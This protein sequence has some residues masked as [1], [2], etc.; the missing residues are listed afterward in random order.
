MTDLRQTERDLYVAAEELRG[1]ATEFRQRREDL[2]HEFAGTDPSD[3]PD[4]AERE[5]QRLAEQI[6]EAEGTA[7]TYD[8]YAD[9]WSVDGAG[10]VFVVEELNGDEYA[11]TIDAVSAEAGRQAR[12][13]GSLPQGYGRVKALEYGIV[14]KPPGAPADPGQWP[15]PIVGELFDALQNL[16]APSGVELG[17]ESLASAVSGRTGETP[18]TPPAASTPNDD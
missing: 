10:C 5:Y 18:D 12:E 4:D 1:D 8:H 13:D 7:N 6:K 14:D 17:N 11:A 15:A 16:T 2:E 9:E 3:I